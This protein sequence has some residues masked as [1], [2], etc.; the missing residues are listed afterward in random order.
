MRPDESN[1]GQGRALDPTTSSQQAAADVVRAQI[2]SLYENNKTS[3]LPPQQLENTN[4]YQRTHQE[5]SQP[6]TEQWEKYHTAW[7]NY[8][9]KY[10]EGYY[11]HHTNKSQY[12]HSHPNDSRGYFSNQPS[13][14]TDS[15]KADFTDEEMF[16]LRQKLLNK[17]QA[18]AVKVR[19]SR[20]F[21]PITAG[22]VVVLLFLFLQYNRLLISNVMAYVSPGN[23]DPQNIVIDPSNTI[24]VGPEPRLIVPKIN[25]DVPVVYDV[26]SDYNSQMIAMTRGV[27]H[28]AIPGA[29][30][31][32]GQIGN[33]VLA[34]H[35][36]N[37]LFDSGDYKFIF[38][39]LD[40]LIEGDTIY[41]NYK[42]IR[43]TYVVTK[44]EVVKPEDVN[45]LVYETTKPV[46]TLLTCT[47]I[48]TATNRLLV[49][50]EQVS[51]DPSLSTAV[52][53][54]E[55]NN[56]SETKSI[57]GNSSTL[58]DWVFNNSRY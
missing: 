3:N 1:G 58:F 28:F 36:S 57:P 20:H 2:N 39:Q 52:P 53:I 48:G 16:D 14:R 9:Q 50:A 51:P 42:S 27:A 7:Q 8:Y 38:V 6:Q 22:L 49:T 25:V 34:G 5:H 17:V 19:G 24:A 32:P 15:D 21:V 12:A 35:S 43:Y 13:D 33:T 45:R 56:D 46:L 18:S 23:I 10:Y 37:D 11:S 55:S 44:K 40:K 31:H 47:P 4:P 54:T 41:A 30:S 26:G 29:S